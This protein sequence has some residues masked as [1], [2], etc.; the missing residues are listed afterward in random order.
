[1]PTQP[2]P[3]AERWAADEELLAETPLELDVKPRWMRDGLEGY[4][5]DTEQ[6]TMDDLDAR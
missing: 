3:M 5:P 4:A 2:V 1:M 6:P